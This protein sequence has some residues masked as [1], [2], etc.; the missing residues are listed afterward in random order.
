MTGKFYGER[1]NPFFPEQPVVGFSGSG[2]PVL[3]PSVPI[4]TE[5]EF[6]SI[7]HVADFKSK[8]FRTWISEEKAE[9]DSIMDRVANGYFYLKDR[10]VFEIK[11]P[12][13]RNITE[14]GET[15]I[16]ERSP[17]LEFYLEWVQIRAQ[18][19]PPVDAIKAEMAGGGESLLWRF[20]RTG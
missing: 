11:L 7:P 9:Y 5:A 19:K 13:L 18:P 3:G 10:R 2:M 20:G 12:P 14:N 16:E 15:I 17:G 8:R 6:E 4:T 1:Y